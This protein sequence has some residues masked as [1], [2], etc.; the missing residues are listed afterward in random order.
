MLK[1]SLGARCV[2]LWGLK[3]FGGKYEIIGCYFLSD[4]R[5]DFGLLPRRVRKTVR[6]YLSSHGRRRVVQ[7]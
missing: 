5:L 3:I 4:R 7:N 1:R 6:R 2:F